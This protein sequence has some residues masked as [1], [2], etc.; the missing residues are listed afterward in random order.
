MNKF[1][2]ITCPR[3]GYEYLP[4]EVFVPKAFI[5]TPELIIREEGKVVDFAGASMNLEED[6]TCDKCN[7]TF[8]IKAKTSFDTRIIPTVDFSEGHVTSLKDKRISMEES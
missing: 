3:C 2:T 1:I 4:A 6:Y 7:C 5:G 8:H